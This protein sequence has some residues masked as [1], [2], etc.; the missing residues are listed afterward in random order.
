MVS[1]IIN[2]Q[3]VSKSYRKGDPPALR[4][5]SLTIGEGD[6]VGL[7]GAN[8]S[9]KTT[10][11]R[12]ILNFLRPDSGSIQILGERDAEQSRQHLGFLPERQSGM[13]N[14]TPREL[15]KFSAQMHGVPKAQAA[16]RIEELLAFANI[17]NV[18]N[19]LL[20]EFSKGMCQRVQVCL[21]L[22]H[23]PKILLLDEPM[24]GLDPSGQ[25]DLREILGRLENITFVYASHDLAEIE[26]FCTSVVILHRG[27]LKEQ[28]SL[29]AIQ[30]ENY[31]ITLNASAE[32]QLTEFSEFS[33]E[34]RE[35]T[36]DTIV[37]ELVADSP[38]F[39]A[40]SNRLNEKGVTINRIRSRGILESLYQRY[41]KQ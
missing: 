8:G 14:F 29:K 41:V 36:P 11:L 3:N 2:I 15:L 24:S 10:L 39:Q 25:N 34:I 19:E 13:E 9:G 6:R 18:G 40:F 23:Q 17:A 35:K 38:V 26:R 4:N 5:V 31:Q 21:A 7:V 16:T 12:L 32:P 1:P 28:L 37:V 20:A 27:E 30:Q 22:L 33:F